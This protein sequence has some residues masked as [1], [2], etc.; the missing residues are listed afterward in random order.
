MYL[1]VTAEIL[2]R[3]FGP[4]H[5]AVLHDDVEVEPYNAGFGVQASGFR[6]HD[7]G[8]RVQDLG[9]GLMI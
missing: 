5:V 2:H 9:F 3:I 4:Q 8:F 6:V 7:S 1:G